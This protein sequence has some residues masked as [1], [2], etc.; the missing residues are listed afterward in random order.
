MNKK[1]L[2][3]LLKANHLTDQLNGLPMHDSSYHL[4]LEKFSELIIQECIDVV[5][6]V[7]MHVDDGSFTISAS[8]EIRDHFGWV[9]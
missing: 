6:D 3:L 4:F 8:E 2:E 1:I 7:K 9:K 5:S